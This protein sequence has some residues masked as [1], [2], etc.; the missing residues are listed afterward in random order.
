MKRMA[1][2]TVVC[3]LLA[4]PALAQNTA[5]TSGSIEARVGRLSFN[6]GK[7]DHNDNFFAVGFKVRGYLGKGKITRKTSVDVSFDYLPISK[8][9]FNVFGNEVRRNIY[10]L[11][12][13]PGMGFDV[14]RNSRV[15]VSVNGGINI[16][17]EVQALALRNTYG[18]WQNVCTYTYLPE[19]CKSKWGI[20]ANYGAEVNYSPSRNNPIYFGFSYSGFINNSHHF[21]GTF[22]VVF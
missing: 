2:M 7:S 17:G 12:F 9:E 5:N 22:G 10:G 14:F 1:V 15:N 13:S 11:L 4:V 21:A 18:Q 6:D 20:L 3:M 16:Y 19:Y 8:E